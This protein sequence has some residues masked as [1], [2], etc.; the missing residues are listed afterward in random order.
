MINLGICFHKPH[1]SL[2]SK[3][4]CFHIGNPGRSR[5][6]ISAQIRKEIPGRFR[7]GRPLIENFQALLN[8]RTGKQHLQRY[9]N[10][11]YKNCMQCAARGYHADIYNFSWLTSCPI[12][13]LEAITTYC[14]ECQLPWQMTPENQRRNTC[15][16]CGELT[17]KNLIKEQVFHEIWDYQLLAQ[18]EEIV[19]NFSEPRRTILFSGVQDT[20]LVELLNPSDDQFP[21]VL[22]T[23]FPIFKQCLLKANVTLNQCRIERGV[24][25]KMVHLKFFNK[26][27]RRRLDQEHWRQDSINKVAITI[28]QRLDSLH[29]CTP[30]ASKI[31]SFPVKNNHCAYCIACNTWM[32]F[33]QS[34]EI[35]RTD[36]IDIAV[37]DFTRFYLSNYL[38][39]PE[40]LRCIWI[41]GS[42]YNQ[43]IRTNWVEL[44]PQN[45][46]Q[47][48]YELQLWVCFI[49]ILKIV[50]LA[51][52]RTD[53]L[54]KSYPLSIPQLRLEPLC[55]DV[56]IDRADEMVVTLP[57]IGYGCV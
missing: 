32:H 16:I 2:E 39:V 48:I 17:L 40:P 9:S 8:I 43:Y 41:S 28:L 51:L 37:N 3:F 1:Q 23:E 22:V 46:Q 14:P 53:N 49:N 19:D 12:H 21:S 30:R 5:R 18:L 45:I 27:T 50:K 47:A 44:L 26:F 57:E 24:R 11:D 36:K 15:K 13:R 33:L 54:T 35:N 6:E 52:T 10:L 4:R 34:N 55:F 56:Q 42:R 20:E 31:I 29:N 38:Y 25:G 7:V